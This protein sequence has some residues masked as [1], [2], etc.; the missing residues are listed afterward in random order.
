V[1]RDEFETRVLDLWMKTRI[2]LTRAHLQYESKARRRQIERWLD[3]LVVEGVLEVEVG[4]Q[5]EMEWTVPGAVRPLDGA[6]TFDELERKQAMRAEARRRVRRSAGRDD[7]DDRGGSDELALAGKALVL[8]NRG[9]AELER[10]KGDG[11]K[12]L[13]VSSG[14]S[15][16]G[17]VGWLYAAPFRESVP[18]LLA[19]AVIYKLLPSFL[20]MPI[21]FLALPLSAVAGLVYALQ[22]NRYGERTPLFLTGDDD[23]K[24]PG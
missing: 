1:N 13:L 18:A 24:E 15:L 19:F 9:R 8:A 4:D 20:L 12:S 5:G 2:P 17:P 23:E 7:R 11:K 21:L 6:T 22:Y 16:L 10:S 3:E 14:L